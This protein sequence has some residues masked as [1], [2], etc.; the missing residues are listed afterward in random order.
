MTSDKLA[1]ATG[2]TN[3]DAARFVGPLS[4]AML[5]FKILHPND[6]ACFLATLA[7]ESRSLSTTTED[8]YYKDAQ[9]LA[10]IYKRVFHGDA[11]KAAPYTRSSAKLGQLLYQGYWGRGLIQLTWLANYQ[12]YGDILGFDYVGHP[13]LVAEPW[14]AAHT[15]AAFWHENDCHTPALTLDMTEVTRK[16]NP[17][18]MHLPE[19]KAALVVALKASV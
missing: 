7:V 17:A 13:T 12:K 5:R 14:H 1:A 9:R 19:R 11:A 4:E 2:A 8:L 18:L 3:A 15:A 16:I 6:K 10:N